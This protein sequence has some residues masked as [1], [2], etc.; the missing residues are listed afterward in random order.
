[1]YC[2]ISV[3]CNQWSAICRENQSLKRRFIDA[4]DVTNVKHTATFDAAAGCLLIVDWDAE[5]ILGMLDLP[6]P[7]GFLVDEGRLHVALWG[8]DEV[9]TLHGSQLVNRRSHPWF[10]HLHTIEKTEFGLLVSSSG[11][12]LLAEIDEQGQILWSYFLFEHGYGES[13]YRLAQKFDRAQNYNHRYLPAALTTHPNSA[14]VLDDDSVLATLFSTGELVRIDRKSGRLDKLLRGLRRPHS[15][16]HRKGSGYMLCDSEAG[17]VV[18]LDQYLQQEGLISVASPWIQDAVLHND[19]L[20]VVSN[21]KIVMSPM[22]TAQE[23]PDEVNC[24]IEQSPSGPLKR[25]SFGPEHRL[26]MVEPIERKDAELF[27]HAWRSGMSDTSWIKWESN[28]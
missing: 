16:R 8:H 13:R 19:R 23:D 18:L 24:V 15:I 1:M 11:T 9:A 21:R 3:V 7:T 28:H 2:L 4:P 6:K 25:L 20:L 26:Y 14:I 22:A 17:R 27:A 10:N 12:D 5:L